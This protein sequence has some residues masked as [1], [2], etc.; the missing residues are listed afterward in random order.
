MQ[1]L[2]DTL[3][4]KDQNKI[5]CLAKN[6]LKHA[7]EM[8]AK[9]ISPYPVVFEKPWSTLIHEPNNILLDSNSTHDVDHESKNIEN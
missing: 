9:N 8:G 4:K 1:N 7:I 6:Y 3:I 2:F 5:I